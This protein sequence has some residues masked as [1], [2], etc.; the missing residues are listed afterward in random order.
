MPNVMRYHIF[1]DPPTHPVGPFDYS[2]ASYS[3]TESTI[4]LDNEIVLETPPGSVGRS[5]GQK[6]AKVSRRK[7]NKRTMWVNLWSKLYILSITESN[8]VS[9]DFLKKVEADCETE[10]ERVMVLEESIEDARKMTMQINDF[11]SDPKVW[12]K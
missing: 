9:T 11:T 1:K 3:Q 12:Y 8:K 10:S 4:D 7:E 6:A 5:M 2:M